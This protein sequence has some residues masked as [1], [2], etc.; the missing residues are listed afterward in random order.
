MPILAHLM[1][2]LQRPI[3]DSSE[4]PGQLSV[5]SI[6][7]SYHT[8]ILSDDIFPAI[9]F[10]VSHSNLQQDSLAMCTRNTWTIFY[11]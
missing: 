4:F 9:Y 10:F 11:L 5:L 2:T 1:A 7:F 3:R 8:I 6:T